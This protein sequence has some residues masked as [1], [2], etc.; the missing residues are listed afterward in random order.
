ME[1]QAVHKTYKYKLTPTPEQERVLDRTLMLCR[2]I[3]NA[4]VAERREA[5]RMR[6]VSV[7]Y[8][9]QKAELPGLKETMPEYGE[10]NSQV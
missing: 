10:V 9:Q 3:Y 4:A 2:H 8:Y 7:S 5:W 1:S 6:G